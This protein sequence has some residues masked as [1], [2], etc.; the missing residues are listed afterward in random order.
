M[1]KIVLLLFCSLLPTLTISQ[2]F[3]DFESAS[4]A[5]WSSVPSSRW[6]ASGN[7]PIGGIYSL[8]HTY[9]NTVNSIDRVSIPLPAWNVNNGSITWRFKIRHGYDPSSSNCWWVYLMSDQDANSMGSPSSTSGYIVGVN[10]TGSDDLLKI[11]QVTPDNSQI[12]L[13]STL[14]WQTTIGTSGI[15]AIEV[16]RSAEGLFSLRVSTNG[17]FSA[18]QD[19]GSVQ[20]NNVITFNYFGICYKYS[21][22][23]DMLLWAD[24]ISID[25]L[26]LNQHDNTSQVIEPSNQV[27][28]GTFSSSDTLPDRAVDIFKFSIKDSGSG[29]NLPTR[30]KKISFKPDVS[31]QQ[32]DWVNTIAGVKLFSAGNEVTVI[33]TSIAYNKITLDVDST[34]MVIPDGSSKEFTLKIYLNP[35]NLEDNSLLKLMVDK[36]NH[37]FL[38]GLSGSGFSSS[39]PNSIYSNPFSVDVIS[40]QLDFADYPDVVSVNK[41][42]SLEVIGVDNNGNIDKDFNKVVTLSLFEGTGILN[43]ATGLSKIP[44]N[45]AAT[46][47]DLTYNS[48]H[49]FSIKAECTDF[50]EIATELIAVVNDSSAVVLSPDGQPPGTN[51]SSLANFPGNAVEVLRFNIADTGQGDGVPT[52]V[53]NI[54]VNR[55]DIAEIASLSKVI[56]GVLVKSNGTLIGISTPEIKTAYINIP[57]SLG[58]LTVPDGQSVEIAILVYLKSSGLIDNQKLQFKVDAA[59]HGFDAYTDGSAFISAFP[60]AIVSN[61]FNIAVIAKKLSFSSIPKRVGVSEPFDILVSAVDENT[62]RDTNF[63]GNIT[64]SLATGDGSLLLPDGET[65]TMKGGAL[66]FT[67]LEYNTPG[68]FSLFISSPVL[69]DAVS[70]LIFCGDNDGGI[71]QTMPSKKIIIPSASV[72]PENAVE[73]FNLELY[74]AGST[75]G[76]PLFLSKITLQCLKPTNTALMSGLIGGFVIKSGGKSIPVASVNKLTSSYELT[77]DPGMIVVP[78]SNAIDLSISVFLKKGGLTD[79]SSFQFFIPSINHGWVTFSTGTSFQNEFVSA[80]YSNDTQIKVEATQ[81]QFTESPFITAY[82]QPF[83][84]SVASTDMYGNIDVDYEDNISLGLE[85]G[86]SFTTANLNLPL[87]NGLTTWNDLVL[88]KT[89]LYRF[90]VNSLE[91]GTALSEYIY[92]GIDRICEVDENFE[93]VISPIW[94]GT[95]DW[96]ISTISP[97][98][99][100]K[101]LQHKAQSDIGVSIVSIPYNQ[102][103]ITGNKM[104]EWVFS[105]KNGTWDPSS[106]N[107]FY[108]ILSSDLPDFNPSNSS[109]FAVGINPKAGNDNITLWQFIKGAIT[110]LII[111]HFDWNENNELTLRIGLTTKGEWIL[112]HKTNEEL[113]YTLA[114]HSSST[115]QPAMNYCGLL[116]GYTASR[117]GLLWF[118][119]LRI[120]IA[121][122]P[123]LIKSAKPINLTNTEITFTEQVNQLQAKNIGNYSILNEQNHSLSINALTYIASTGT[124]V[125]LSTEALPFGKLKLI[126][127]G[128]GDLNGR[129]LKDSVFF[130]FSTNGTLGRLIMNEIMANPIPSNGLPEYEYIELFNPSN[131]T[132]FTNGWSLKYNDKI[133]KL[134]ADSVS[135]KQYAVLCGTTAS[136]QLGQYGKAIGVTGFPSLLN[137]GMLLKLYDQNSSLIDFVSYSDTWYRDNIKKG[138]GWA[139][140]KIDLSNLAEGKPNWIASNATL[141]GTPCAANSVINNNPDLTPPKV[142]SVEIISKNEISINYS[143]SMDTLMVTHLLNYT[144]NNNIGNPSNIQIADELFSKVKLTFSVDFGTDLIYNLCMSDGIKDFSGNKLVNTCVPI[145]L[146]QIPQAS[147]IIINEILFNPYSGGVDFVEIFNRS[148]KCIELS[149]LGLGNRNSSTGQ[150]ASVYPASD[151]AKM[152]FPNDYAVV[153]VDPAM[154]SRFYHIQNPSAFC[155]VTKMAS[156]NNDKGVV[157]LV[158]QNAEVL[159]EFSY[160]EKMHF[161][162]ISDVKGVSLERVSPDLPTNSQSTWHSAAQSVGFA[163]PTYQNSQYVDPQIKEGNFNLSPETF[164]PDGDGYDDFLMITYN[165]PEQGYVANIRIFNATGREVK[166]IAANTLLGTEGSFM[167]DGLNSNN[168]N[169]PIGIY[170]VYIEYFNLNGE[171][172]KVKKTCVVAGKLK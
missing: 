124:N 123:P 76:Q 3:Y 109:G 79:N 107:Y 53:S 116:F 110:P 94:S 105:L 158:N 97:I 7:Q 170:L 4:I 96:F 167:W 22:S 152:L 8:K 77:F 142:L 73:I 132:V 41:P 118:D 44:I 98:S 14:N 108:F 92:C 156:F 125:V 13:T 35:D 21:S 86:T 165:L 87:L 68:N 168:Q 139:L 49:P 31:V 72:N 163:T 136:Q 20:N 42:F 47:N 15:G 12:L 120:C 65:L 119:D 17:D 16:E 84:L 11:W 71:I 1:R 54:K 121:D 149:R 129:Y 55:T 23:A 131:D 154:V 133:V 115:F 2:V 81:L 82:P 32:A 122:Y 63:T 150:I 134:P 45:G 10:F 112:W 85:K 101:S 128:V 51:I 166:R 64:V 39:F 83:I 106:D 148:N 80:L 126:V 111:S 114:G 102:T 29:D 140:E 24:D 144:V 69:N 169:T 28:A 99:G 143:E 25:Y 60:Q 43:S 159:D 67:S 95:Q 78:D 153:T 33:N 27:P 56:Q 151:T 147:D 137:G 40:N 130:G 135:P 9:N 88:P 145:S 160:N 164:S 48:Y 50:D 161:K 52:Y 38:A 61:I 18:L 74:D 100:S 37:G 155:W 104:V 117:S 46:W 89:G 57:I 36:D 5:E 157:V 127:N 34:T 138:G 62:N 171:V 90:K 66:T 146:P 91:L 30:V 103:Q 172:K 26:A 93:S 113:A 58:S 6:Q 75:D 70:P 19:F 162:L 59:N 141:G